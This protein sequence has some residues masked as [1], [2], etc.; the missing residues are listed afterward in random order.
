MEQLLLALSPSNCVERPASHRSFVP[1]KPASPQFRLT[2]ARMVFLHFAKKVP[3][4]SSSVKYAGTRMEQHGCVFVASGIE[5][6][7]EMCDFVVSL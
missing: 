6:T 2:L 3:R 4:I 7:A 1:E 5:K